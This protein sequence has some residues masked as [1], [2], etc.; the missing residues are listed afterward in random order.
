MKDWDFEKPFL[1]TS[2]T[3]NPETAVVPT[4]V[5]GLVGIKAKVAPI[6]NAEHTAPEDW[7]ELSSHNLSGLQR[8][9]FLAALTRKS[10]QTPTGSELFC[11]G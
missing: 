8:G 4:G 11:S 5:A 2:N 3:S 1:E 9:A 7:D 6:G 10:L